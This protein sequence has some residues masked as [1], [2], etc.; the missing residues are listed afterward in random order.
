MVLRVACDLLIFFMWTRVFALQF[1]HRSLIENILFFLGVQGHAHMTSKWNPWFS[2]GSRRKEF[3]LRY[4]CNF[5]WY[6]ISNLAEISWTWSTFSLLNARTERCRR[7]LNGY[8][9][10]SEF[11]RRC[12]ESILQS[13]AAAKAAF[14]STSQFPVGAE[15][16]TAPQN[17]VE[18]VTK[19]LVMIEA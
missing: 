1:C 18:G 3:W 6:I 8:L 7:T 10:D 14:Q 4:H 12:G 9:C 17:T 11:R 16:S 2:P 5:G 13:G 15:G 19:V